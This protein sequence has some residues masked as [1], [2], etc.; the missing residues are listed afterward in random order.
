MQN[1][2]RR[3]YLKKAL[4]SVGSLLAATNLAK[5]STCL[6]TPEQTE[7]PFYPVNDQ[8]D[9]DNDLTIIRGSNKRAQ[10]EVIVLHGVVRDQECNPVQNALVEIWQACETGRYNHPSDPNT[11]KLDPNFQY[12]GRSITNSKGEYSFK[13]IRPGHYPA[14]N[15]W[16]RP[17]HI[18]LKVHK[19]GFEELTTQ[20]YFKDDPYNSADRII[21]SLSNEERKQVIVDFKQQTNHPANQTDAP[22]VGLFNISIRSYS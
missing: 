22:R 19:R 14:T 17:A 16:I 20:V 2:S 8:N 12:W 21:Q 13:T 18:H 15:R 11:A 1:S 10:G 9:K 4:L 3:S 6:L 7:G 5:A